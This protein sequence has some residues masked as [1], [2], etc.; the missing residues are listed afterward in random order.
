[1]QIGKKIRV[2]GKVSS[3]ST[4]SSSKSNAVYHTIVEGDT[5]GHLAI[6]YNTTSKKIQ[7][8][9]PN[10]DPAKIQIGQKIRVK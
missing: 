1:M 6:K 5:F 3:S 9:N 2:S 4:S 10:V 7:E 8:L